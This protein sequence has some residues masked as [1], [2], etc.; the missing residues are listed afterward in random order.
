MVLESARF[1]GD[2]ILERIRNADTTAYLRFGAQGEHVRAVQFAL[3]DLGFSIPSGATGGFFNETSAAVVQYKTLHGLVPNDPVVGVGT[4]TALDD[5]WALPFADRDEWL[6]WQTRPIP[7]FNFTRADELN[8]QQTGGQFTLNPL[9]SWLPGSF[10]NAIITGITALLDP[11]GSPLGQFT[12]SATWGMSPLDAF[13]CHVVVDNINIAP[14]WSSFKPQEAQI[15]QRIL[16]MMGQAD[17][18]GPEGMPPWTAAYRN[19]LLAPAQP[20][21]PKFFDQVATL[22]N[23]LLTNAQA[24]QQTV[25]LVWHTF[26]EKLWRPVDVG[27]D[28]PRRAWWNDVAPVPSGMTQWPFPVADFGINVFSLLGLA[29]LIDKDGVTTV[30]AETHVEAAALVNLDK[31]RIEA[32]ANGLPFP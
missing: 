28:H 4:M 20:G 3:I 29:F 22:L 13:H 7:E 21:T 32:A 2:P 31:K 11:T 23:G 26:E 27:S 8:R 5:E 12:P 17:Q 9:S 16:T 14:S 24:E 6:S 30:G 19:L 18:A 15:H 25:K 10:K 1:R